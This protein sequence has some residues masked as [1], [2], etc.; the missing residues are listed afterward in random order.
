MNGKKTFLGI[1]QEMNIVVEPHAAPNT[2]HEISPEQLTTWLQTRMIKKSDDKM[3]YTQVHF[4]DYFSEKLYDFYEQLRQEYEPLGFFAET[5]HSGFLDLFL[6]NMYIHEKE[7]YDIDY[8][9]ELAC[10]D[11]NKS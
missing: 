6:E 3:T 8:V 9:H 2:L 5:D 4:V 1:A 10:D 11:E 7:R